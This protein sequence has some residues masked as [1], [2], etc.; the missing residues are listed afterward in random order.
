MDETNQDAAPKP[1]A[2]RRRP[3]LAL[4][5][6]RE[7]RPWDLENLRASG[8]TDETIELAQLW[9]EINALQLAQ[10][11]H[12]RSWPRT[13]GS[14]LVIPFIAP[15]A[16]EPHAYRIRPTRPR[17]NKRG[18]PVKYEQ[19]ADSPSLVYF[20]PRVRMGGM[21]RDMSTRLLW[22]EGEKKALA[23]DQLGH[24]CIGLTGVN[25]WHDAK[26]LDDTGEWKLHPAL[27]EHVQ[28]AGRHHVILFDAD[29]REKD[30]VMRAAQQLCGVL[31]A[32]GAL[33]VGFAIPPSMDTKGI[34]D[35][36]AAH[37]ADAVAGL[38]A[39][40]ERLEPLDP[41]APLQLLCKL[42]ALRDAPIANTLRLPQHYE[43]QRDGTIWHQPPGDKKP[44]QVASKPVLLARVLEDVVTHEGRAEVCYLAD[45]Q[46]HTV[47]VSRR[48]VVDVRAAVAELGSVGVPVNSNTAGRVVDW[49]DALLA[50]N[51]TR[52]PRVGCVSGTGWHVLE[53]QRVFVADRVLSPATPPP[54]VALDTRGGRGRMFAALKPR[55]QLADHVA[56]LKQAYDAD[57]VCAA[58]IL[59][60]L[61]APLLE[62][63]GA[64]NF[65]T[66]L[67]GDSTRGKTTMLKV[68]AS[69]F[70]DPE[71]EWVA[72]WNTTP[73]AAELRA[74]AWNHL[75]QCYD[76]LGAGGDAQAAER[77][78][79]QLI[80]GMGRTRGRADL[81][82][83]EVPTW[84]CTFLST[85]ERALAS[86]DASTG[87]QVRCIQLPVRGF[88]QLGADAIDG[89]R[90][91]CAANAGSLGYE[92]LDT[93]IRVEDWGTWRG[94]WAESTEA[95]RAKVKGDALAGRVASYFGVLAVVEMMV[96]ACG[97][98]DPGANTVLELFAAQ[99]KRETVQP[100]ADRA[101][102]LAQD[103]VLAEPDA[104]P[105]LGRDA[106]DNA[107]VPRTGRPRAGFRC[108]RDGVTYFIPSAFSAWCAEHRLYEREV[109]RQW[110]ERGWLRVEGSGEKRLTKQVRIGSHERLYLYALLVPS[111]DALQPF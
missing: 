83:R 109:L 107:T 95:M 4:P 19:P 51:D 21:L 8:L 9:T 11:M 49:F 52:I 24:A 76:E 17:V 70:G 100:L 111:P 7:V 99:D 39:G 110:R 36:Y 87:A 33:S 31:L 3:V 59:T 58:M 65:A 18:K 72:S 48:A 29:A 23:L 41:A 42:R 54:S 12:M 96:S 57:P 79:Y 88:G 75:P 62:R 1:A 102:A 60:A 14:A 73:V 25:N 103:W 82:T 44:V 71:S 101:L 45:D 94:L 15:G 35:F 5:V 56:A 77:L 66:H 74:A 34:D 61:A 80:N 10:L 30:Q 90:R 84:S 13:R 69:V 2:A 55:G 37:G 64:P 47:C 38:I 50:A 85:G 104:F 93:L 68:A 40:A 22:T 81:S 16:T 6:K 91:A 105:E 98:G 43:V 63:L 78:L 106:G 20:P 86:S 67:A 92:W 46:W 28:I 53:G 89:I 27:V 32:A 108:A 26:L 97:L